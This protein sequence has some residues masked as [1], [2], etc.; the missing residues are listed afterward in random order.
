MSPSPTTTLLSP[1]FP[2]SCRR[3]VP[4]RAAL[5]LPVPPRPS[6]PPLLIG[7]ESH[8]SGGSVSRWLG[9]ELR[10]CLRV[11]LLPGPCVLGRLGSS[12]VGNEAALSLADHRGRLSLATDRFSGAEIDRVVDRFC[13]L[14]GSEL[15]SYLSVVV[16]WFLR[17]LERNCGFDS[18]WWPLDRTVYPESIEFFFRELRIYLRVVV[19]WFLRLLER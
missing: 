12:S 5:S 2:S 7:S 8:R 11:G 9:S 19:D 1:S 10:I 6:Q 16:D 14:L 13:R 18:A 15:R 17:L 4:H 3:E